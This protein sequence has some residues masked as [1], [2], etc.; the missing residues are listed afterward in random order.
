MHDMNASLSAVGASCL[1][2]RE[3]VIKLGI[4]VAYLVFPPSPPPFLYTVC[5]AR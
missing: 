5:F 1:S 4:F 2:L 3:L